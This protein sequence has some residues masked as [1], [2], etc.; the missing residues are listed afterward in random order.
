MGEQ[1]PER[2]GMRLGL[3]KRVRIKIGADGI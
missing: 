2:G 1:L 3:I